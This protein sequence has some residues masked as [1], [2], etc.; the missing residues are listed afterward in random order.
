MEQ[1]AAGACATLPRKAQGSGQVSVVS[2]EAVVGRGVG[3][4]GILIAPIPVPVIIGDRRI[5]AHVLRGRVA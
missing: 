3:D 4:V 2:A 1:S 5:I